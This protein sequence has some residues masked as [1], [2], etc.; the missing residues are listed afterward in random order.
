MAVDRSEAGLRKAWA[1]VKHYF[2]RLTALLCRC[3]PSS[4]RVYPQGLWH[5]NK[6][7]ILPESCQA[8]Q[9]TWELVSCETEICS[10]CGR[11]MALMHHC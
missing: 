7:T 9:G 2:K 3:T 8:G 4:A 5:A 11:L 10:C 1:L 6:M